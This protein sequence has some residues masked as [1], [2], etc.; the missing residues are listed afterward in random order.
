MAINGPVGNETK[1]RAY[2]QHGHVNQ[3]SRSEGR[4]HIS[5]FQ[6]TCINGFANCIRYMHWAQSGLA[7]LRRGQIARIRRQCGTVPP[8][9][10]ILR[11]RGIHLCVRHRMCFGESEVV[12][13]YCRKTR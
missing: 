2:S 8:L 5:D 9:Y 4:I 12:K 6:K 13:L 7:A 10:C 11:R 3:A 1:A